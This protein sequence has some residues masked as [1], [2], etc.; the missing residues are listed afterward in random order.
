MWNF[1]I[2]LL[3][4]PVLLFALTIHEFSHGLAAYL[5]G[6][7]TPKKAGR[8]TLNPLKHLD[9]FGTLTLFL[10]QAIGWAK[11]VPINPNYFKNPWRD[12]AITSAAGPLSNFFSAIF[13][14]LLYHFFNKFSFQWG[15]FK[16]SEPLVIISLLGVKINMGLSL[17]NF[18]PIPP[19]DGSKILVKFLPPH[20]REN[21]LRLE[22]VGFLVILLLALTGI[23]GKTL[24]PL[25]NFLSNLVLNYTGL[26][27]Y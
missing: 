10:T 2:F 14:A 15:A 1:Q 9:L 22:L 19:L 18:L 21:Y 13:F 27:F 11:P 20:L 17:F 7:P 16:I 8:L 3:L 4:I 5:L 12:M 26:L 24:Y 23:L 25:L 6:D